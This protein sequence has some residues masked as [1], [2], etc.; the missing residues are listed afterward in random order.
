MEVDVPEY[1]EGGPTQLLGEALNGKT[2][3]NPAV[4]KV[5]L[6]RAAAIIAGAN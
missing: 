6:S 5:I 1:L 2:A 4:Y 3:A